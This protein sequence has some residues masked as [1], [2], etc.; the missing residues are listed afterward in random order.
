MKSLALAAML[1][2]GAA[3]PVTAQAA[4]TFAEAKAVLGRDCGKMLIR[5]LRPWKL[6]FNQRSDQGRMRWE[7]P[8]GAAV[9]C[10]AKAGV[11][12][13]EL[14]K[15]WGLPAGLTWDDKWRKAKKKIEAAGVTERAW[16]D[17]RGKHIL[18]TVNGVK[19]GIHWQKKGKVDRA[20][21]E[22][23]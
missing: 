6:D 11:T 22:R 1:T 18:A 20:A 21:I 14:G 8:R 7:G 15:G 10:N 19:F 12:R 3:V 2:L 4:P 16:K 9:V 5:D 17:D 13:V 23:R